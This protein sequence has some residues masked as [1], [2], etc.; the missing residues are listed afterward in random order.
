MLD[1]INMDI[2]HEPREV[3]CKVPKKADMGVKV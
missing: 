1:T 2:H 3:P